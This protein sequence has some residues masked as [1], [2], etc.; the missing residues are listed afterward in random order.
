MSYFY[1]PVP[2]RRLGLSLGVDLFFSSKKI[3]SF[4]CLYCQL[5]ESDKKVI[6][7]F[8]C[9]N[10]AKFKRELR[11]TVKDSP[12][13]DYI[14]VSGSGE[15]TL[16]KG[17]DKVIAAIKKITQNKYP[18]CVITNSSFL[19]RREV[20]EELREASLI[21][22]SLDAACSKTFYK[23][24]RPHKGV[25]FEKIID[26][27]IK[28][29]KEFRGEIWLEIMLAGGINDSKKEAEEFREIIKKIKPD[30]VQL[31]LPVRPAEAEVALPGNAR[32]KEIKKIIAESAEVV[33]DFH[34]KR[35][36]KHALGDLPRVIL[37][38]LRVRPARL[39]DLKESLTVNSNE[40]AKQLRLLLSKKCIKERI[41]KGSKYFTIND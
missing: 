4:D 39:K 17:L 15:P 31:N 34:P 23:I 22:P 6:R 25:T 10:F 27:L 13:I 21:I 12:K 26:G 35:R 8:S 11:E 36:E 9:I 29:R 37:K 30:K 16:H 28:L 33:L 19:Y 14:T 1:G 20:R 24:N 3:C 7:R 40:I 2:S 5:G 18:V 32:L 38:F 41:Y